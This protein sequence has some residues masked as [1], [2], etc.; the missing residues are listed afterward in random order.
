MPMVWLTGALALLIVAFDSLCPKSFRDADQHFPVFK[1]KS[2]YRCVV[3]EN[4]KE[5]PKTWNVGCEIIT[6][7]TEA[8]GRAI[9]FLRQSDEKAMPMIGDTLE[10]TAVLNRP[11][12]LENG[13]DYGEYLRHKGYGACG[14][15]AEKNWKVTGTLSGWHGW[16]SIKRLAQEARLHLWQRLRSIG[17]SER[18]TAIIAAMTLGVKDQLDDE[19]YQKFRNSGVAHLLAISGLHA[20]LVMTLVYFLLLPLSYLNVSWNLRDWLA[21]VSLWFYAFIT[22]LEPP[23]TRSVLMMTFLLLNRLLGREIIHW[24]LLAGSAFVI[25][26]FEPHQLFLTSFQMTYVAVTGIFLFIGPLMQIEKRWEAQRATELYAQGEGD[27]TTKERF[28]R[29]GEKAFNT[30]ARTIWNA[31]S[32]TTAAQVAILPIQLKVFNIFTFTFLLSNLLL[33]P[34]TTAVVWSSI[35]MLALC[36]IPLVGT[37][38][39]S[40]TD[41]L[42]A[43]MAR[44][45]DWTSSMT[46]AQIHVEFNTLQSLIASAALLFLGLYA[47]DKQPWKAIVFMTLIVL[48]LL[49]LIAS[50]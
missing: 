27:I 44:V 46:W 41:L 39:S 22:G 45:I 3:C 13:F 18:H 20:G 30:F 11:G 29:K 40:L 47:H 48:L 15:V 34:L 26:L 17:L 8:Y 23:V 19:T 35:F 14:Y 50:V 31:L 9:V 16:T 38:L 7:E 1:Q 4:G 10:V 5:R 21:L 28:K 6:S 2:T 49:C 36:H 43:S 42:V 25:L 24:N 32:V 33:I 37:C 12:I